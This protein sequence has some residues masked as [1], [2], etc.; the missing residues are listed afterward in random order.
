MKLWIKFL[1][2]TLVIGIPAFILG[3][4]IWVPSP[5]I[6]PTP[7]Q[8]PFFIFLSLVESLFLGFGI[9]FI[10][11]G[12]PLV[13]KVSSQSKNLTT[14]AFFALSWLLVSWWPHDNS[15][16]HNGMNAQGLLYIDYIFHF[17]LII[18]TLILSYYFFNLLKRVA[19][20]PAKINRKE[21]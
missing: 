1:L 3:S 19:A 4:I 16:I 5:D 20:K 7:Q 8:I 6:K 15:H 13:K 9:A 10:I 18:S 2:I 21:A 11:F 17:T 14:A 12:W